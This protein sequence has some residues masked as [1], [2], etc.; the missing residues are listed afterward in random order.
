M[1][2]RNFEYIR[3]DFEVLAD[4]GALAELYAYPDSSGCLV[5][6]RTMIEEIVK[7]MYLDDG[8][9][10]PYQWGLNDLLNHGAFKVNVSGVV[11]D[12]MHIVRRLGNRAAHGS[13]VSTSDA[14]DG[15]RA[16]FDVMKWFY[17]IYLDGESKDVGSYVAPP[18]TK[19]LVSEAES[20]RKQDRHKRDMEAKEKALEE[21]L[22]ELENVRKSKALVLKEKEELEAQLARG[23]QVARALNF[24]ETQTRKYLID[25]QLKDAGWDIHDKD[26]VTLEELV[27][28]QPTPSGKGYVDYVLW[29]EDGVPLAIIEAK[30]FSKHISN[31]RKQA[32]LYA[33]WL[34]KTYG[35]RP[36]IYCAN[37]NST[38]ILNDS[39][40][41]PDSGEPPR[42]VMGFH[43]RDSLEYLHFKAREKRNLEHVE[44]D[45]T[46][47]G[48]LYQIEAQKRILERL[49]QKHRSA[50][51]V[52]A[53]GTGKTRTAISLSKALIDARWAKR[54][55]F[56]CDRR[57]LRKQAFNAF[58]EHLPTTPGVVVHADTASDRD[59]RLYFATYPAMMK[60]YKS[61]DIGFFDV[62]IADESHRS[63]YNIYKTL[64]DYFDAIRIGLTAT[65]VKFINRNTYTLFGCE[66]ENPTAH[67]SYEDAISSAPPFLVPFKV[68]SHTTKFLREGIKYSALTPK[69]R[70]NLEDGELV[71]DLID[72]EAREV[73]SRVFNKDTNLRVLRNLM[74]NG[75]RDA[76][77]QELGKT[78]IF[79]RNHEHAVLLAKLFDEEYPQYE[80]EFCQVI[81]YHNQR[82]EQLIE[83]FKGFGTNDKLTIAISVDMLDTG[84]DVP[85]IVNL[86]FAK[87]VRSH[88]KFWQMIGRGTRLCAD[89]FGPGKDKTEFLIFDH[90]KN[91]E[92]FEHDYKEIEPP[93]RTSLMERLF[94][95]RVKLAS[96]AKST[97]GR[98]FTTATELILEDLRALPEQSIEVRPHMLTIKQF[99]EHEELLEALDD[100]MI[101][102]LEGDLAALMQWR[103]IAGE[104]DAY[105]FDLLIARLQVELLQGSSKI[106][107]Y[108]EQLEEVLSE[109]PGNLSQVKAKQ[110]VIDGVLDR[111]FWL[112]EERVEIVLGLEEARIALRGL[113]KYRQRQ[114]VARPGALILDIKEDSEAEVCEVVDVPIKGLELTAYRHRV[115]EALEPLFET[116]QAL[117]K[118]RKGEAITEQELAEL[119]AMVLEQDPSLDLEALRGFYPEF[120]NNLGHVLQ[121]IVG[122]DAK[123]V[124]EVFSEF[125]QA[126]PGLQARQVKFLEMLK[127]HIGKYGSV[128]LEQ[129]YEAPFTRLAPEG[130]EGVFDDATIDELCDLLDVVSISTIH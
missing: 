126:H 40:V 35:R 89:L 33:D 9:E 49:Q 31:G 15:L 124:D 77:G 78:I 92:F 113:M 93:K 65:P 46:I 125:V 95:A 5:K 99:I 44:L 22:V 66:N 119:Q 28:E 96:I 56:L 55:L 39:K 102:L 129:L 70:E 60:Y 71:P 14:L 67:Y 58:K 30:R 84:I 117:L 50:L 20:K 128:Q 37:G 86:V 80:G 104:A 48:R 115:Y 73:D 12:K 61:F 68:V 59:K 7:A 107:K 25:L 123:L 83:D 3:E 47:A 90:W 43:S 18:R 75:I 53:T 97:Y 79:A 19:G 16:T 29:G 10:R 34:E 87:P 72:F 100:R 24:D 88:V 116:N 74:N 27:H 81:D 2:S 111:E 36:I 63:V 82:A 51:L 114:N 106:I 118:I 13:A 105:Q 108:K 64:F 54:I 69:Q 62:I 76:T 45:A 110:S 91:F 17:L 109:L 130:I 101:R 8:L 42:A 1:K 23:Q 4:Y 11:L 6:L 98:A 85:E 112:Q 52:L 57:E 127:N 41:H 103:P 121:S 94:G 38:E 120:A 122:L 32:Q 26:Q 21:A